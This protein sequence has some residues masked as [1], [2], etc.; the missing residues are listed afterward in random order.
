MARRSYFK[1]VLIGYENANLK[2]LGD[3]LQKLALENRDFVILGDS[4]SYQT[5][6]TIHCELYREKFNFEKSGD[7]FIPFESKGYYTFH[8]HEINASLNVYYKR[9]DNIRLKHQF[10]PLD[11]D[12]RSLLK[13][14]SGYLLLANI[15]LNYNIMN[16]YYEDIPKIFSWLNNLSQ[17]REHK[18]EVVW[19][20]T[21]AS[22]WSYAP[23][24]YYSAIKRAN[25]SKD[26]VY[27][28]PHQDPAED[29]RNDLVKKAL[30]E[31]ARNENVTYD[32]VHY[33]NFYFAT[34]DL[35]NMH[36]DFPPYPGGH[37]D[38]VH[39]CYHPILWQPIW[40]ALYDIVVSNISYTFAL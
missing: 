13:I 17:S 36:T 24:G 14:K 18:V 15:G 1:S 37:S 4:L 30:I 8:F 9:L 26:E 25:L 22:H 6:I 19:R 2:Y 16:E 23:N 27:C 21:T 33:V 11:E 29:T 38:C 12:L 34:Q 7:S 10:D 32:K 5:L 3:F 39:F 31:K 28:S 40:K 35:W 20:E